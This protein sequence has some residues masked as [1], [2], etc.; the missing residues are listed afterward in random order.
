MDTPTKPVSYAQDRSILVPRGK[1]IKTAW[2]PVHE[3]KLAC[4]DRMSIGDVKGAYERLLQL[5][6]N[7]AWPT[8]N[9][10]WEGEEQKSVFVIQDGRHE[11]VASLMLGR[12][13]VL[14]SWVT[15]V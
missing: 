11:Y 8:P 10:Y 2:V 1:I 14:V 3:I 7:A 15:D 9:G 6:N 12:E 5:G 4:K 13:E